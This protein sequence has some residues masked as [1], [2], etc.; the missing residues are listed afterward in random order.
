MSMR[1]FAAYT[2]FKTKIENNITSN[3]DSNNNFSSTNSS[4]EN[5]NQSSNS[6]EVLE[7]LNHQ[8][9]Y[10]FKIQEEN[11]SSIEHIFYH[12]DLFSL[13]KSSLNTP[14]PELV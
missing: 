10:Y 13:L 14:P 4:E 1:G 5:E 8:V 9:N 11:N 12:L 3:L 7:K 2:D 6:Y